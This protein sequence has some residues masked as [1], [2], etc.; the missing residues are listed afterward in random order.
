MTGP[1]TNDHEPGELPSPGWQAID[2]ALAA[3]YG[4]QQPRHVGYHPPAAFSTNLQGCS[5]YRAAGH[6]HYVSYGLSELYVPAPED[7]PEHSGWGFELTLRVAGEADEAPPWPF[8]MINEIAKWVNGS[9]TLLAPGSRVDL[10]APVTGH[11]HVPE[12]PPTGLPVFA[13]ALDPELGER[14]TPNGRVVFLQLVGV[15]AEEKERM[16]ASSTAAVLADLAARDPLLV[17]DPARA[18]ARG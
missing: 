11:P 3:L 10:Q 4:D 5:A 18:A 12:A 9:H 8:T 13:V 2:D 14:Q 6:W 15:T 7:D 1:G 17:T 16:V